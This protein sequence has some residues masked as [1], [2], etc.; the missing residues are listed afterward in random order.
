MDVMF[1]V[2][3]DAPLWHDF[4]HDY[5]SRSSVISDLELRLRPEFG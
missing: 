4:W 2:R 3:E 5:P 1:A